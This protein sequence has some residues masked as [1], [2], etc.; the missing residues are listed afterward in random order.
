MAAD[1]ISAPVE[2]AII[3]FPGS[4]F[5][6]EIV[7]ALTQLV[8]DGIVAIIDLVLVSKDVDG[9]VTVLELS[10]LDDETAGAF[11]DLDGEAGGLLSED[12]LAQ[13]AEALSLG[14]S[15]L[16]IVWQD[17]WAARLVEAIAA[18]GG[19]SS[20]TTA[21]MPRRWPRCSPRPT[22]TDRRKGSEMFRRPMA[23]RPMGRGG[24][25][26]TAARTAV[27]A[28]T[29][30]AVVGGVQ[31][32]QQGKAEQAAD[33]QAYQEQQQAAAMQAAAEQAAAQ[34]AAAAPATAWRPIRS[35]RSSAWPT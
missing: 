11:D 12:D 5:N 30:T 31:H 29:A 16:M 25:L 9:S 19:R 23:R 15:A 33:A 6:G 27:V 3:E 28:G 13:A 8:D 2:I 10:E 21:W 7:P 22:P 14:S 24:L 34:Q 17:T 20:P 26:G 1:T 18:S 35:P 4:R 32:R